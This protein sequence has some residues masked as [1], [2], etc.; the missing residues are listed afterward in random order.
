LHRQAGL[1]LL[2]REP[3]SVV[4]SSLP[5]AAFYARAIS[6]RIPLEMGSDRSIGRLKAVFSERKVRYLIVD[7]GLLAESPA[8]RDYVAGLKPLQEFRHGD[9]LVEVFAVINTN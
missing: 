8:V 7:D 1:F 4:A 3:G 6:V 2:H 5:T 9:E